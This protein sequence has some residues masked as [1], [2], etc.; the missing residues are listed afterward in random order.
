MNNLSNGYQFKAGPCMIEAHPFRNENGM[1][2][3]LVIYTPW[4]PVSGQLGVDAST[5]KKALV[6]VRKAWIPHLYEFVTERNPPRATSV[7]SP[8]AQSLN[9]SV[10]IDQRSVGM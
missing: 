4:G 3:N 5:V 7:G 2:L 6:S 1:F 9:G 10:R 8:S